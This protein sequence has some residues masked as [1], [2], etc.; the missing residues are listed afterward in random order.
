MATTERQRTL[1]YKHAVL[2]QQGDLNLQERVKRAIA[3]LGS[4]AEDRE[5]VLVEGGDTRRVLSGIG[6]SGGALVGRLMQYT[7]GQRQQFM[8]K[9]DAG[10]YVLDAMPPPAGK[11]ASA[12]ARRE[13]VESILYLGINKNHVCFVGSNAL[14]SRHLEDHLN[15]LL[16]STG[17]IDTGDH[18]LLVDQQSPEAM[19]K[20]GKHSVD[21]IEIGADLDFDPVQST[22]TK[23]KSSRQAGAPGFKLI[24]PTGDV[25]AA[26][27]AL[28]GDWFGDAPL[29]LALKRNER[30]EFKLLLKYVSKTKTDEGFALMERLAV[31]GRHFDIND[32]KVRLHKAGTLTGAEL[33]L[34]A[35]ITVKILE[36]GLVEEPSLW[37]KMNAWLRNAIAKGAVPS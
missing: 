5:Q 9:T 33:K 26:L 19:E 6:P 22:P 3:H 36:S 17:N 15:W 10:D 18:L 16:H 21:R 12:K 30:I 34:E 11:G 2:L 23:R 31:A 20:I 4:D 25:A 24:Q 7:K 28:L 29:K 32:T 35:P 13:F 37:E 14:G 1:H 27:Q 8:E